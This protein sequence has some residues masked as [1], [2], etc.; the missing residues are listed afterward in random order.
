MPDRPLA[1][2]RL[3]PHMIPG[4]RALFE[5]CIELLADRLNRLGSSGHMHEAWMHDPVSERMRQVYN[6]S[7]MEADDGGYASLRAYEAEL[8]RVHEELGRMEREYRRTEDE[9]AALF[10]E[11][12]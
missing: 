3:E 10:G 4:L 5:E 7:V 2:L 11:R 9:T 12:A 1:V 8:R 6:S